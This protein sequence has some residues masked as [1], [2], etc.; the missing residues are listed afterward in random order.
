VGTI[1]I[2][3]GTIAYIDANALIYAVEGI[4]PYALFSVPYGSGSFE[5]GALDRSELLIIEALTVP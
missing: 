4:Q 5:V 2:A 3:A 1:T